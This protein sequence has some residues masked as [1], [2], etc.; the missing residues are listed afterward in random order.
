M[1]ALKCISCGESR[2]K[3]VSSEA[4]DIAKR[5]IPGLRSVGL[6]FAGM[7]SLCMAL[8]MQSLAS[9]S[10]FSLQNRLID[11]VTQ[12]EAEWQ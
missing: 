4:N 6:G 9:S 5:F 12:K 1:L 3:S 10:Y 11:M 2:G 7:S 8:N